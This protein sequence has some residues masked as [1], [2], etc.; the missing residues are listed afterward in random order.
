[1][2]VLKRKIYDK[3]LSWKKTSNGQTALLIE[4]ARRVG[5]STIC[6]FFGK[7]EYKSYII[8]DFV[9]ASKTIKENFENLNNLDIF[10]QNISVEYKTKLYKRESLIVFDEIQKF[11]RAREALKYLIED[12]RYDFIETGSLISIK[13]NVDNITVPSEEEKISMYPLDFEEFLFAADESLLIDLIKEY[14]Q[15]NKPLSDSMHKKAMRLFYEYMLVGGMPKSV[16]SYFT[17]NRDFYSADIEKRR[18]LELYKNDIKKAA[19]KYNS[20]IS[21]IFENLP[22]FLST[23]EKRI[24]LRRDND[25]Y[26]SYEDALFWLEDSSICNLCYRCN[27]P[28]VGLAL[29]KDLSALKCY[30]NDTGLLV[31]LTFSENELVTNNLYKSILNGKLSFN[32]GMFFENVVA[33]MLVSN[34]KKLYFYT[35]YDINKKRN[36]IEIDFLISNE[37]YSSYKIFPLEVKS[38]KNYTLTSYQKFK[39]KFNNKVGKGIII[40]P[41]QFVSDDNNIRIPPY[42]LIAIFN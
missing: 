28:S 7:N 18:I 14:Y 29:N 37:S 10:Y 24:T 19:K 3:L 1:M 22:S 17:N 8:I 15:N 34:K 32:K 23:H 21:Y 26:S 4:G 33:Q 13:E 42:M 25:L 9:K 31:S 41:K 39:E 35:H 2:K 20:K 16:L 12:G 40:H 36:D 11:P 5:K 38:S 30:L 6:E 27:D